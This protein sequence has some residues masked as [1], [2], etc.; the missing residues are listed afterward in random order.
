MKTPLLLRA[1]S[2]ADG[3]L[4]AVQPL[5]LLGL[6]LAVSLPFFKSGLVKLGDFENAVYLFTEEY[7]VP[8]LSPTV[9]AALATAGELAFPVLLV[10]GLGTR[11]AAV[12]L[13]AVNAMAVYAYAHVLLE[14]GFEA[15][16][17]QHTLWGVMLLVLLAFGGGTLAV[18]RW[19]T[20]RGNARGGDSAQPST[21]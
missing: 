14:P 17:G 16:V 7:R 3:L 4:D 21:L 8:L 15:A 9:A 18:D 6:R 13:S 10:L 20:Q 5:L 12:G 2:R 11:L 19:L 1:L